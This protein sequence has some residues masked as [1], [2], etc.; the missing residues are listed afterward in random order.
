M[1]KNLQYSI[2]LFLFALIAFFSSKHNDKSQ[3]IRIIEKI[4]STSSPEAS[5]ESKRGRDEYFNRIL[6]DPAT[7]KIPQ[8]IRNRELL[9]AKELEK[10][11]KSLQKNSNISELTWKEAG[12]K[13]VGGRTRALAIDV[14]NKTTIIVGGVAGGIW[15]STDNGATWRTKSTTSQNLSVTSIAQDKRSGNTNTW[16]YSSGELDGS[17]QDLGYTAFFSGGG[18]YKSTD[19]GESWNLL[20]NARDT[21]PSSW[22]TPFD[23]VFKIIVNPATGSVFIASFGYGILRSQDGGNSFNLSIGGTRNHYYSD[24]DISADGTIVA[25]LSSPFQG[26]TPTKTP[27]V[28]KSK[29]D[30]QTWT[31]ITPAS[32]PTDTQRSVVAIAPSNTNVCYV[33]TYTGNKINNKIDDI[34]FHKINISTGTAEDRSANMPNFEQDFSDFINT[35]NNYNMVVAVKPDDE[36]FVLIAGTSLFRSTNGFATKPN[37][38]KLDWIG[39][40]NLTYFGYP[41]FHSDVHSFAFDP[42]NAKAMWWGH[43]GGLTYTSD[44]T[45]TNYSEIFPWET[46][47]NG[48]NVTQFYMITQPKGA[49]DNRIMG[50]TQDNGSPFF[51]FDGNTISVS[52]DVSSG[53]GSYGYLGDSFCYAS[54]QEGAVLRVN[55]DG[56]GNP[57][58]NNGWSNIT[59]KDAKNQSFINPY[60]VDPNDENIML[61]PSGSALWRNNQLSTLPV[62]ATFQQGITQGWTELTSVSVPN[63]YI[64]SALAISEGNPKHRLYYGASNFSQTSQPPKVFRL[65]NANTATS[66]A[67]ELTLPGVADNSYIHNIAINPDN[68]DE[69]IV[70]MSNYNITGIFHSSNGG[71]TFTGIEGSLTGTEANPG[72]SIRAAAILTAKSGTQYF[73]AT[74]TGIYSTSQLNG[75]NTNW[76][77]EGPNTVGNVIVSYLSA[78]KSDGRI[79]AGTHGRGAFIAK[80]EVGGAAAVNVN[81]NSLTLNSRPGESGSTS[82]IL[83]NSGESTLTYNISVNGSFGSSLAKVDNTKYVLEKA[84]LLS[85]KYD[86]FRNKSNFKKAKG[87][88][89]HSGPTK[90]NVANSLQSVVGN[91]FLFLDDGDATSDDFVGWGDGSD[92]NWYNEFNVSGFNFEMDSFV[93]YL[94]TEQSFTNS[95]YAAIYDQ[96]SKSA[97]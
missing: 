72:P 94:R 27:G 78:R 51:T 60:V 64:I 77:L 38:I 39:G 7:G 86:E 69:V 54:A 14:N 4:K 73:V 18:I 82:F 30:G 56:S 43:D 46:K 87:Y 65:D 6:K 12:P 41:N 95:I 32:L 74:S 16:Y 48:Y 81:V 85:S 44:I 91:D 53:D 50:G 10:R 25:V 28:Y 13:D 71:Q 70:V 22:N 8:N 90:K 52:E 84:D 37:N 21:N 62:N 55:Y 5:L 83:S 88:P 66:G 63:G 1:K 36:N 92:F 3:S 79:V 58:R 23:Y 68:A 31:Q 49:G 61:Y 97:F 67:V 47:N 17:N 34:R 15:K 93:F 11:N 9:F 33:M 26:T 40:Y 19:N 89:K 45:N 24:F 29:D 2:P 76:F 57:S 35:Q 20:P 96:G 80:A 42:T 59:P 75:N